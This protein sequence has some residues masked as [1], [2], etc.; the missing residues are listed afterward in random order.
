MKFLSL[1]DRTGIIETELFARMYKSYGLDTI[2]YPVLE[3][4]ARIDPIEHGSG[5]TL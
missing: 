2:R 1:A 4:E 5:F 3:I